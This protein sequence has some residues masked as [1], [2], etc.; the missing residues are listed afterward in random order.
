M[1]K[2]FSKS[3]LTNK[4]ISSNDR[5][6]NKRMVIFNATLRESMFR[7]LKSCEIDVSKL[8]EFKQKPKRSR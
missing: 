4:S 5:L 1:N 3:K 6:L 2:S 7:F 8:T